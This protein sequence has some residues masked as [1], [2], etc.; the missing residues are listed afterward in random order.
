MLRWIGS[1]LALFALVW[2]PDP[3]RADVAIEM[4]RGARP[5][6]AAALMRIVREELR[7]A[8]VTAE[9]DVVAGWI[10]HAP[11]PA[12]SDPSVTSAA[13][14]DEM[15]RG[16]KTYL[17][18]DYRGAIV[19]LQAA[20]TRARAN[21]GLVVSDDRTN[22]AMTR[23][24]VALAL[25]HAREGAKDGATE[26]MTEYIRSLREPVTRKVFGPPGEELYDQVRKLLEAK[27]RGK[28]VVNVSEPDAQISVNEHGVGRGATFSGDLLPARYRVVVRARGLMR[29]YDVDVT[30]ERATTLDI[31]WSLDAALH[32]SDAWVGIAIAD[33]GSDAHYLRLL[34]RRLG[35]ERR[36]LVLGAR[37]EEGRLILSGTFYTDAAA[38][39]IERSGEVQI[40]R[41]ADDVHR[42]VLFLRGGP[43]RGVV[44]LADRHGAVA[45]RTPG[46]RTWPAYVGGVL[47]AGALGAGGY[48]F[49]LDDRSKCGGAAVDCREV[50]ETTNGA[51]LS[52]SI[53]ALAAIGAVIWYAGHRRPKRRPAAAIRYAP[54]AG[55]GMVTVG[56]AF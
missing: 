34:A 21:P 7:V 15:E 52:T 2:Q 44:V 43:S 46:R 38:A 48:L 19:A 50:Y 35:R 16:I 42:L 32:V 29:R 33:G 31:D 30:S 28:L 39:V 25:S 51:I 13:L 11:R 27:P 24:M 23:A 55:G 49:Y 6:E 8:D 53:G 18:A 40:V 37:V 12:I 3:A 26:I 41:P 9:P 45:S 56:G 36:L 54:A 22:A 47:A 1:T 4:Y 5:K 10:S 14:V 17:H 20:L